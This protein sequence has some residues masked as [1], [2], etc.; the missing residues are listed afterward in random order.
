MMLYFTL[1]LMGLYHPLLASAAV[2]SQRTVV[3]GWSLQASTCLSGSQSCGAGAC[4]P[5]SLYCFSAKTAEVASCCT[6]SKNLSS[7]LI[8]SLGLS[9]RSG[10]GMPGF[11]GWQWFTVTYKLKND[12]QTLSTIY[13]SLG[14][15]GTLRQYSPDNLTNLY[16]KKTN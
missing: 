3:Q 10:N 13:K 12:L 6:S 16:V 15:A 9:W 2:I 4:C 11:C 1:L 8:D 7:K 14:A 5:S